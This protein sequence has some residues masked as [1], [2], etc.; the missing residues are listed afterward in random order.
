MVAPEVVECTHLFRI[1]GSSDHDTDGLTIEL[2][3]SQ[4]GENADAKNDGVQGVPSDT[5]E[6]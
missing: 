6:R 2:L 1:V 5:M 4:A 3:A